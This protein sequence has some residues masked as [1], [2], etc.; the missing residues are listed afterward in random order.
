[1]IKV[2]G[3]T[4]PLH[5]IVLKLTH[6]LISIISLGFANDKRGSSTILWRNRGYAAV[7]KEAMPRTNQSPVPCWKVALAP[8]AKRGNQSEGKSSDWKKKL[9][10]W[11]RNTTR[12]EVGRTQS[13]ILL[14][15]NFHRKSALIYSASSY[16]HWIS[17]IVTYGMKQRHLLECWVWEQCVRSGA[18]WHGQHQTSGMLHV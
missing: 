16:R 15:T 1:M 7:A 13:T 18:S 10:N 11:R 8:H 6:I 2:V 12:W 9:P 14:F 3:T 4:P 5:L 17:K